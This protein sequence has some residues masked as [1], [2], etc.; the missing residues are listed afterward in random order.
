MEPP[1]EQI[2]VL[3]PIALLLPLIAPC[4]DEPQKSEPTGTVS[5]AARPLI[6]KA[7]QAAGGRTN[8]LGY[9]TFKDN[10]RLGETDNGFGAK[11]ESVMDAPRRSKA[12]NARWLWKPPTRSNAKPS[13]S[14]KNEPPLFLLELRLTK[15]CR[16]KR[17]CS[18]VE[19]SDERP[20]SSWREPIALR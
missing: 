7:V 12:A 5:P 15:L 8:L 14:S 16:K 20:P 13:N 2:P 3:T 10:V 11:R 17:W 1:I 4:A 18:A 19:N 9:F 6:R